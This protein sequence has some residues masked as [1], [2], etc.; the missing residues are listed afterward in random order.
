[1]KGTQVEE[2]GVHPISQ[3]VNEPDVPEKLDTPHMQPEEPTDE[4]TIL[5]ATVGEL[6]E[7]PTDELAVLMATVGEPIEEPD[8]PLCNRKWG[9]TGRFPVTTTQAGQR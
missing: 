2:S 4:L 1:M 9:K 7:K 6:T 3:E 8:T 5:M